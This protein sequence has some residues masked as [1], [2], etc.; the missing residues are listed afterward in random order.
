LPDPALPDSQQA[1]HLGEGEPLAGLGL[2]Q[3]PQ[4]GDPLGAGEGTAAERGQGAADIVLAHPD[5]SGH[6]GRVQRLTAGDLTLLVALLHTLQRPPCRVAVLK[7]GAAAAGVGGLQGGE[8]VGGRSAV[9]GRLR[10]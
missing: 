8:L 4:L 2:P 5:L 9:A 3:P 1:G 7:G 10:S 6:G